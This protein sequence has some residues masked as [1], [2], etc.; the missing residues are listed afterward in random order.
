MGNHKWIDVIDDLVHNYNNSYHRSIKMTPVQASLKK[1]ERKVRSNLYGND[2]EIQKVK[3]KIGDCV[4]ISK[5]KHIFKKGF[6]QN[7]TDEIFIISKVLQTSPTTYKLKDYDDEEICGVFYE[8]ELV[9][10]NKQDEDYE[11]EYVVK[12]KQVNGKTKYLVKWKGYPESM[13]A[14]VSHINK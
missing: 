8:E 9:P 3:F 11:I 2:S 14:W 5:Y 6:E 7:Y 12:T 13:N 4:R 10:F 1:N